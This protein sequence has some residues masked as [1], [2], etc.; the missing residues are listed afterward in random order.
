MQAYWETSDIHGTVDFICG[1]GDIMFKETT[2]TLEKRQK[3]GKGGRTIT[4]PTTSTDFGYVFESCK[5][6]DL[7]EGMGDWNFGRTW[8]NNPICVWLNTTLDETA[9]KTIIS[10]RWTQKGMNSRDPKLFGEYGTMDANGNDITPASNKIVSYGGEFETIL[11]V[12]QAAQ[13]DYS[14]MF[15]D[16]DPASLTL[17]KEGPANFKQNGNTLSWDAMDGVEMYLVER[18]GEH[19]ALTAETTYT[20]EEAAG[21]KANR[22]ADAAIYTVRAA[23]TMGGFGEKAEANVETGINSLNTHE[24]ALRTEYFTTS[25]MKTNGNVS[26]VT[27]KVETLQDGKKVTTKVIK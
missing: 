5:V 13:F 17:Q 9:A 24:K 15:T 23:N 27:I 14:K 7:A 1:G 11:S 18:D 8:Q 26:G 21:A 20:I 4:A 3:D 19:I 22:S 25:G 10:S 12:E 2:L 16:W 6:V